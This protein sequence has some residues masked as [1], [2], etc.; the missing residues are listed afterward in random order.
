MKA[1]IRKIN[2]QKQI[3][4]KLPLEIFRKEF[5]EDG[6]HYTDEQLEKIRDFFYMLAG[7]AYE[8]YLRR[9]ESSQISETRIININTCYENKSTESDSLH[10][11][12][13]RRTG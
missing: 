2:S 5:G 12:E 4:E 8:Q 10:P 9:I 11:G 7:I 3:G 6:S 13:Y 1:K